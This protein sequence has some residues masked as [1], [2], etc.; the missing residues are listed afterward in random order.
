MAQTIKFRGVHYTP[1]IATATQSRI[2]IEKGIIAE[3]NLFPNETR[4]FTYPD[5]MQATFRL[6]TDKSKIALF[7]SFGKIVSCTIHEV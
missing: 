5:G 1:T 7:L 3:A 2:A 6:S 4:Q